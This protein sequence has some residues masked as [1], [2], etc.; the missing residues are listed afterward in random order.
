MNVLFVKKNAY[1]NASTTSSTFL[2]GKTG[3]DA[4]TPK[5]TKIRQVPDDV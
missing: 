4:V 1:Y 5:Q 2:D 3:F